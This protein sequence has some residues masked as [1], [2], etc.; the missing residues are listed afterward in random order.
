VVGKGYERLSAQDSSFVLFE[1]G[2]SHAHITAI[3]IFEL[4]PLLAEA[5]G[6][7]LARMRAH[8]G[9]RLHTLPRYRQKLAYTFLE[10]HPIWVDDPH[11]DLRYHVRH[12][13]L[14]RPGGDAELKE[15]AG[16]IASQALDRSKPLWEIWFVEGLTG[17]RFAAIAKVHH[18]LV[19]GVSGVG[20]LTSLLSPT[21][22]AKVEPAQPW[23]PRTPP[24]VIDFLSDGL[25]G[26]AD[27]SVSTV[28]TLADA[29]WNPRRTVSSVSQGAVAVWE[30]LA[31]GVSRPPSTP[32][33]RPIGDQRRLDW[34]SLDLAEVRDLR[35]RLDGSV[36]DVVLAIVAGALRRLLKKRRVRL[37][38]LDFRITVPVDMRSDSADPDLA[39]KVSAWFVTLPVSERDPRRRFERIRSQTRRLKRVKAA[40]GIDMF[41]RLADWSGST[42]LPAGLVNVV[43]LL[44]PYNLIVSNIPGPQF[45][46]YL[47]G[48]RLTDFYPHLPLFEN[49]GLSVG[50]MSYLGRIHFGLVGDWDVMPDLGDF[51]AG[52]DDATAELR[53]A[54][55]GR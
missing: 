46:L 10:R 28:K 33:N 29:L 36:N 17:D 39:N 30:T 55:N 23:K 31:G 25:A 1:G 44:R 7:D 26:G 8:I 52:L 3:A 34:K 19:D 2:G 49:Q 18:S 45:P 50:A 4:G 22:E 21:P 48:A 5:G 9:S 6:I 47:L 54:A 12:A 15:L 27:F 24:N 37:R 51:A 53:D 16:R 20:V 40:E 35:K 32:I 42:L 14:P 38:G 43:S 41:L 13:A 11:F